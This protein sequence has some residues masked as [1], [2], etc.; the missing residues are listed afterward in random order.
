VVRGIGSDADVQGSQM[1][2]PFLLGLCQ[3]C[4]RLDACAL[5]VSP[6]SSGEALGL[7]SW[8]RAM[9][10]ALYGGNTLLPGHH[11]SMA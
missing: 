10:H 4:V 2:F 1:L 11:E 3:C 7:S 6:K 8:A 9:F 5:L